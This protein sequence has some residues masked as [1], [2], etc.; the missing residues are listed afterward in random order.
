M[1]STTR[2]QP[3]VQA[4]TATSRQTVSTVTDTDY[5]KLEDE[6]GSRGW[7]APTWRT[8]A[9]DRVCRANNS[10]LFYRSTFQMNWTK[11]SEICCHDLPHW[12]F[13]CPNFIQFNSFGKLYNSSPTILI[14]DHLVWAFFK[15]YVL[16][17]F[18]SD[19]KQI[20]FVCRQ[21]KTSDNKTLI[22]KT[23]TTNQLIKK[24]INSCS[25]SHV[26]VIHKVLLFS[27]LCALFPPVTK[28]CMTHF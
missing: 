23:P 25:R 21:N 9:D 27:L 13:F 7:A 15:D 28:K 2:S 1:K 26:N 14:M 4:T 5:R 24:I 16:V 19:S 12:L 22:N 20:V 18:L 10:Y 11:I 8:T 3:T 6:A 17:S